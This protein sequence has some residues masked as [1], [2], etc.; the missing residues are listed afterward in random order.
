MIEW[1]LTIGVAIND[2]SAVEIARF[3]T[4]KECRYAETIVHAKGKEARKL[5]GEE[6]MAVDLYGQ[7]IRRGSE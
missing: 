7:C 5:A 4:E 1:V 2:P 6:N 3:R